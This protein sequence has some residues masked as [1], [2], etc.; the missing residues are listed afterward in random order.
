MKISKGD[1]K[2]SLKNKILNI[3]NLY[4]YLIAFFSSILTFV[5]FYF[6][7]EVIKEEKVVEEKI[8]IYEVAKEEAIKLGRMEPDEKPIVQEIGPDG[9]VIVPTLTYVD[10][11]GMGDNSNKSFWTNIPGSNSFISFDLALSSY[12]GEML[13]NYLTDYDPDLRKIVYQEISKQNL[14]KLEGSKGKKKLLEDIK[15]EF[16]AYFAEKELDPVVFGAHFKVLAI[17]TRG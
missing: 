16:N 12:Q 11:G 13:T 10:I 2:I 4:V 15:N 7:S 6:S 5:F 8:D 3:K 1:T 17:T 14:S 9:K